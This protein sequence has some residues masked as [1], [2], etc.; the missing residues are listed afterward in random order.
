MK[1]YITKNHPNA[2]IPGYATMGAACFDLCA[3]DDGT[4]PSDCSMVFRTG[5]CFEIPE[6][7]VM[8]VFSRSGHGFKNGVRLSNATGIIDS[9]YRGE[10]MIK[11]HNDGDWNFKVKAGDR[12]AQAMVIPVDTVQFEEVEELSETERGMGGLGSTGM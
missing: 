8:Q 11:L 5:L 7:Y 12:I 6:G 2:I 1:V 3:I 10:L 9:D 4:V